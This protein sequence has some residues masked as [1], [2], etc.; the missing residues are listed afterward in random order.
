MP[1][2]F[3]YP[4]RIFLIVVLNFTLC[5]G[6]MAQ[7]GAL[8]PQGKSP[9]ELPD[10]EPNYRTSVLKGW[11]DFHTSFAKDGLACIDCHLSHQDMASWGP[12][13]PQA[14]VFDGTEHAVKTLDQVVAEALARHTDL[15]G[16]ARKSKIDDLVSFISWWGDGHM[17][18][19]GHA[20]SLPLPSQD[21][22]M[23]ETAVS[24]GWRVFNS[25]CRSCHSPG[26][27]AGMAVKRSFRLAAA[28]YPRYLASFGKV[29][30]LE[31]FLKNHLREVSIE[32]NSEELVELAA[33][34]RSLSAG[35]AYRPGLLKGRTL[36]DE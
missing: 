20:S 8:S 6:V 22:E 25:A 19:P 5:F 4:L 16:E 14:H 18:S 12:S 7:G 11:K 15:P 31:A 32:A 3:H 9:R 28:F 30:S 21:L 34:L 29:L 1:F 10:L 17:I 27:S 24:R 36:Y 26:S 33:Y 2:L 35:N 23:L 13:Y